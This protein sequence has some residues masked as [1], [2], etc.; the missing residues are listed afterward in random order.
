MKKYI[1]NIYLLA[2]LFLVAT[3]CTKE[4]SILDS[5]AVE[6]EQPVNKTYTLTVNAS[7]GEDIA[8]TRALTLDGTTLNSTWEVNDEVTV[9]NKTQSADL[10]GTLK[11]QSAGASTTLSGTLSGTIEN[12]DVLTLKFR[13]PNYASQNGTLAYI[14]ANC[15]YAKADVTVSSVDGG[16]VTTT[17]AAHF[18]NQQAIVKFTLLDKG[19]SDAPLDE[20]TKLAIT[21][22]SNS[23][24]ITPTSA[25]KNE[26]FVA[27][28]GFSGQ[29]TLNAIVGTNVYTYTKTSATFAN[30]QY[31][32]VRVKMTQQNTIGI[33][34]LI[35]QNG[36]IYDNPSYVP[37]STEAVGIIAYVGN[38]SNCQNGL[39]VALDDESGT[40]NYSNAVSTASGHTIVPGGIWRL[41]SKADWEHMT[42]Y[43]IAN[44]QR[45]TSG[46]YWT[47]TDSSP[48]SVYCATIT[49]TDNE[50]SIDVSQQ[51]Y[52]QEDLKARAV[53]A[54]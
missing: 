27:I 16:N 31:Y 33:G 47:S 38:K 15:D 8:T 10:G 44:H 6:K 21:I 14:A 7:K 23:Y 1:Y 32:T 25:P 34:K 52:K 41:P 26:L 37:S 17:G 4:D 54:F 18:A 12:G 19:N 48:G 35:A 29:I 40:M 49:F 50:N 53:L 42:S 20:T 30:S 9:Y 24:T 46:S 51:Q 13:S 3:A 45:L 5:S 22:G 36:C 11:A 39:A 43:L 2:A 28:P